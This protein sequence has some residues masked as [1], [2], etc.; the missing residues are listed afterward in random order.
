MP[1]VG[2]DEDYLLA[3]ASQGC[4]EVGRHARA[5]L[6]T[7][8]ASHQQNHSAFRRGDK[9]LKPDTKITVGLS[10]RRM[11][12][13]GK[14]GRRRPA[15]AANVEHLGRDRS[16]QAPLQVVAVT[17]PVVKMITGDHRSEANEQPKERA[18]GQEY[19]F[20][21]ARWRE[22]QRGGRHQSGVQRVLSLVACGTRRK[23]AEVDI[24]S[25]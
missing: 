20:A 25:G 1:Q 17:Y 21:E 18:Y 6:P 12:A 3:C 10:D 16:I 23:V 4:G 19:L 2:I 9:R 7:P 13:A 24:G 5:T 22:W 8:R 15:A 14:Y 11:R